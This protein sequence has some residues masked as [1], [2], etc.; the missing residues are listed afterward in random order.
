M[1]VKVR[2]KTFQIEILKRD[3]NHLEVMIDDRQYYLD[4]L[5]V[6]NDI[7]SIIYN[8]KSYNL[9]V[10]ADETDRNIGVAIEGINY[11]VEIIDSQAK[12]LLNR[13]KGSK[14]DGSNI[15][16]SPM[17]GKIVKIPVS[18]GDQVEK[19][20]TLIIISAMK[21]ESE[22]KAPKACTIKKIHVSEGDVI[23]GHKP[24]IV[25]E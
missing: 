8:G 25:I 7:Y 21:M 12:Y 17:P 3:N 22:Y 10:V 14:S 11:D 20:T 6:E 19:G 9:E 23:E 2:D 16:T 1:E 13:R 15:I 5:K 4:L 24:L 18:E